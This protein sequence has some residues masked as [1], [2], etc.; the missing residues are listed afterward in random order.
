MASKSF[1]FSYR[2]RPLPDQVRNAIATSIK[3]NSAV[4]CRRDSHGRRANP[5][6]ALSNKRRKWTPRGLSQIAPGDLLISHALL[7][8]L[9]VARKQ[10]TAR[11]AP[12]ASAETG[13]CLGHDT[14]IS[15]VS[16]Y[17]QREWQKIIRHSFPGN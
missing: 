1:G 16:L 17:K 12:D 14:S 9:V 2:W 5:I 7:T 15:N 3:E 6:A 11:S 13:I 8:R 4:L 10:K